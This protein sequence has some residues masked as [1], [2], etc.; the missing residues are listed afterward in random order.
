MVALSVALVL[1][2]CVSKAP[3]AQWPSPPPPTLAEPIGQDGVRSSSLGAGATAALAEEA[4][5]P[6]VP[7]EASAPADTPE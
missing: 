5:A 4:A 6:V 2:A 1:P 3:P 7:A